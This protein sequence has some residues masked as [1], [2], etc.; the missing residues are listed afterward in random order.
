MTV[1]TILW[2]HE[3]DVNPGVKKYLKNKLLKG[4]LSGICCKFKFGQILGF[5][6]SFPFVFFLLGAN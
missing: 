6:K 1:E 3:Q 4:S 2:L 5:L